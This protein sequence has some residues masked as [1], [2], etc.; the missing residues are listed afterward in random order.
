M[1]MLI[2]GENAAAMDWVSAG[3]LG[4]DQGKIPIVSNA[5]APM[6]WPLAEYGPEEIQI[7]GD[8][9][10]GRAADLVRCTHSVKLPDGWVAARAKTAGSLTATARRAS[11]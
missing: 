8:V 5:F 10:A 1:G 6:K 4:Y 3:L 11:S 9:G 7:A 2:A